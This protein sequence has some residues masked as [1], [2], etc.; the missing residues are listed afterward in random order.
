MTT[1]FEDRNEGIKFVEV[2]VRG[3]RGEDG[4]EVK[5]SVFGDFGSNGHHLAFVDRV[6]DLCFFMEVGGNVD[7]DHLRVG[8]IN[9]PWFEEY[10]RPSLLTQVKLGHE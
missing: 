5:A 3:P 7:S 8:V 9:V 1:L 10:I 4:F 6:E 2:G